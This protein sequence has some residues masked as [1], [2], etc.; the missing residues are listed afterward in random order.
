MAEIKINMSQD[1][2]EFLI[3]FGEKDTR[4][5][6]AHTLAAM[7][8]I[9]MQYLE[10]WRSYAMGAPIPPNND[11]IHSRRGGYV[12]S[13]K[14][15]LSK[16]WEKIIYT[17]SKVHQYIE[18][19]HGP[20]DLKPGLLSGP[21]ARHGKYGNYNI[22]SFRHGTPGTLPSNKPMP[23]D[24]YQY[25]KGQTQKAENER[26]LGFS[27]IVARTK[28]TPM[29]PGG[30]V[31]AW[32]VQLP[33]HLGG[34]PKTKAVTLTTG[35]QGAYTWKTGQYTGMARMKDV[36]TKGASPQYRTFRV[37]SVKS[38]PFSWIVP[39]R[40][41]IPI[42]QAVVDTMQPALIQTIKDALER[43]LR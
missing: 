1:V 33:A 12:D 37:V 35:E 39:A 5:A 34:E 31:G 43:D 15:D 20:I 4:P 29:N 22:V 36:L 17:I 9:A 10:L 13:I 26:R 40:P 8:K 19:G 11:T 23:R 16:D 38:D 14:A 41:P 2:P 24:V 21:K 27:R 42:R 7:N 30:R 32:G 25:M 3:L 6:F 18:E 28:R